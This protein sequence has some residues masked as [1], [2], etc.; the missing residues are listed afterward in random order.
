VPIAEN[1]IAMSDKPSKDPM[2]MFRR[3]V[4][5][6]ET[7]ANEFGSKIVGSSEFARAMQGSTAMTLKI[8]KATQDAMAKAL[9]AANMP[10]KVEVETLGERLSA[11]EAQLARIEAAL[12]KAGSTTSAAAKPK[13]R[14][15]R[16]PAAKPAK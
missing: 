11:I 5:Q 4:S 9:A 7:M 13:P 8:Q 2:E 12:P 1:D 6:W 15:T 14:R 10:S 16:K 3:M